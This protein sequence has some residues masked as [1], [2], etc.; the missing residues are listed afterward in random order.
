MNVKDLRKKED[1]LS[2]LLRKKE[3]LSWTLIAAFIFYLNNRPHWLCKR[4]TS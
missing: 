3:I 2:T 4:A 1:I